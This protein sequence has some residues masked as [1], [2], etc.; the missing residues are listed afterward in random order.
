M[1]TRVPPSGFPV[2]RVPTAL[3]SVIGACSGVRT[4]GLLLA[5]FLSFSSVAATPD[6]QMQFADGL[7][8]RGLYDMA[9]KEYMALLR[10]AEGF[11]KI[12]Q[13]LYRLGECHRQQTNAPA[14]DVFYRRVIAEHP[15]SPFRFKAE[16]RRAEIKIT[17]NQ[18]LEALAL[19]Q[20]MLQA[21]PPAEIASA[22]YYYAGFAS[23]RAGKEG[24]AAPYFQKVV[25]EFKDSPYVP[26]AALELAAQLRRAGQDD[27]AQAALYRRTIEKP[28]SPELAAEAWF[29][30]GD[31]CYR[32][33][34]YPEA[35]AAYGSLLKDHPSSP[36]AAEARQQA[37]WAYYHAGRF[38]DAQ[39]LA[40]TALKDPA[41][42]DA[43]EWLYLRANCLRQLL[44]NS[45]ADAAYGDLVT[46]F[47]QHPFASAAAYERAL[48]AFK[49]RRYDAVIQQ[50]EH[51]TPDEKL[52]GDI[53]WLLAEAHAGTA[54][55]NEA[56]QFFRLVAEQSPTGD[57]APDALYRLGRLLQERGDRA[58]ASGVY[59][60]LAEKYPQHEAASS[61]LFASAW[62]HAVDG[63]FPDAIADWTRVE[64]DYPSSPPAEESLFQKALAEI[65]VGRDAPARETLGSFL[66]RFPKSAFESE[67]RFWLG[68]LLETGKEYAL[69]EQELRQALKLDSKPEVSRKTQYRLA[70]LLQRQNKHDEAADLLQGL[71]ATPVAE[72][73]ST[74]LLEWLARRRIEQ[75]AWPAAAE[76]ASV[77]VA[78]AAS[79]EAWSQIAHYLL[80]RALAGQDKRTEALA[81]L[82]K[83]F[84]ATS[85]TREGLAAMVLSGDLLR[86][87]QKPVEAAAR[88]Y[89]AA[90]RAADPSLVDLKARALRGLG[91]A[92]EDQ[93]KWDDAVRYFLSASI[94]FDDPEVSPECLYRAA[95]AFDKLNQPD[96]R[97]QTLAELAQRYPNSEWAKKSK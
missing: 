94:L 25:D 60:R 83:A 79:D 2:R 3:P 93:Q 87:E 45:A 16:F 95:G 62:C 92:A 9:S 30:L 61:A 75:R 40:E 57:R 32:R 65:R 81:A 86:D 44:D 42:K 20:S 39:S 69:A 10:D 4:C 33:R 71:L 12:D 41:L 68:T 11:P 14:A 37:A 97:A 52:K 66:K 77:L 31:L 38:A 73:M 90:E 74:G 36:R 48:I 23:A 22:A 29:Q 82:E 67:A 50:L 63:R 35:A 51:F 19:L 85:L 84:Q 53:Y 70:A 54:R 7:Y 15:K 21:G 17:E 96:R 78:R 46:R 72:E 24:D 8:V 56:V 58:E 59:R 34:Q 88:Y 6:E 28:P 64:K 55:T 80:G 91:R 89:A 1:K 5:C 13:A 49:Q 18:F 27:D 76:A 47:P 26:L 43:A